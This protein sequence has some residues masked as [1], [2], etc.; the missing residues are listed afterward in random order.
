MLIIARILILLIIFLPIALLI[1]GQL[2]MLRGS[3]P[4]ALGVTDGKLAAAH[5]KTQN[6][7]CSQARNDYS[8]IAPLAAGQA[9]SAWPKLKDVVAAMPGAK[10]IEE[11]PN[12]LRTE[13]QTQWLKFVDDVEFYRDD[14][15]NSIHMRSASRLGRK[16]FGVNRARL[17]AIRARIS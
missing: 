17:E 8:Q 14:T 15:D 11:R 9:A 1:A 10:I 5:E 3:P 16:D 2:G 6:T 4:T 13:F 7:V 12:Y